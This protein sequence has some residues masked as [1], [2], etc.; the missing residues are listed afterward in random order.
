[1]TK[2]AALYKFYSSFDIAAF[3]ENSVPPNAD[4]ATVTYPDELDVHY[5]GGVDGE[6]PYLTYELITDS[7]GT[8]IPLSFSIWYRSESWTAANAKEKEISAAIGRGGKILPCD[9]GAIWLKRGA[10]FAQRMG[11]D[12]DELVKRIYFNVS[13][14]FI[15]AD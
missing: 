6:Y 5:Y 7:F 10:P 11:D 9:G 2:A 14:E 13:A 3:E 4:S 12:S 1:M 15:T 8:E